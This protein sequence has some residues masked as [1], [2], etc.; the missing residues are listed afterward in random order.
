MRRLLVYE[1]EFSYIGG[2]SNSFKY[3]IFEYMEFEFGL[4]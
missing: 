3:C 2:Y 4:F 1:K